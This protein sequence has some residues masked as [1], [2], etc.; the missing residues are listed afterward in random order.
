[1]LQDLLF[2][3]VTNNFKIFW[4]GRQSRINGQYQLV[5]VSMFIDIQFFLQN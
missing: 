4:I 2:Y 3:K 5:I 1:M